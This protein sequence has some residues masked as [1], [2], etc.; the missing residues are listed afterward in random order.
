[1]SIGAL[2]LQVRSRRKKIFFRRFYNY[3]VSLTALKRK[4]ISPEPAF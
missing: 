3:G 2:V 4:L 1:M